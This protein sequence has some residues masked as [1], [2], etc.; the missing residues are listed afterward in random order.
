MRA[1]DK[2]K[3]LIDF[4]QRPK[5]KCYPSCVAGGFFDSGGLSLGPQRTFCRT[6]G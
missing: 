4:L 3:E 5:G 6:N 2:P 1:K